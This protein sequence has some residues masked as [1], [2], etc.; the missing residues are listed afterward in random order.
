MD[1]KLLDDLFD[2]IIRSVGGLDIEFVREM[3][4]QL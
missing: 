3:A 4:I 1:E 2:H